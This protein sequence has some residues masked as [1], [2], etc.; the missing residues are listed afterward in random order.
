[1]FGTQSYK[2]ENVKEAPDSPFEVVLPCEERP[3]FVRVVFVDLTV[4]QK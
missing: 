4:V 1:M 2:Q 3:R